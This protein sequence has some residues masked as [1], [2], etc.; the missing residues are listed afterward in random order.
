MLIAMMGRQLEPAKQMMITFFFL[1]S[2]KAELPIR[3]PCRR[4][5][6][7]KTE[8]NLAPMTPPGTNLQRTVGRR[9]MERLQRA[10]FP[11]RR[12]DLSQ[13]IQLRFP[14]PLPMMTSFRAEIRLTMFDFS[15][16]N[17]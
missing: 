4:S 10:Q 6:I 2:P 9:R 13:M 14:A 16:G 3:L 17:R 11:D 1:P 15:I 5:L 7:P 8:E 12:K